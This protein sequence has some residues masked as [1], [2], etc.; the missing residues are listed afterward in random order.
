MS[1][2]GKKLEEM[3]SATAFAEAGEFDTAEQFLSG[4]EKVLLVLT[5]RETDVKSLK[6]ALNIAKRTR[7]ALEVLVTCDGGAAAELL[8]LCAEKARR[9][10]L[11]LEVTRKTGCIRESII[12]HARD[13][14]DL[15]CVVIDSTDALDIDCSSDSQR[16]AGIWKKLGCPLAL[17]TD[18]LELQGGSLE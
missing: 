13:R 18:K 11:G 1:E 5:G 17:V 7:A 9:E 2:L 14:N 16:L 3:F 12:R 10:S 6:Y 4:K 8:E 15:V